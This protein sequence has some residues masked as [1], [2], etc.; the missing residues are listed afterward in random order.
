LEYHR[1]VLPWETQY[2][3]KFASL[4]LGIDAYEKELLRT[5][6]GQIL[7]VAYDDVVMEPEGRYELVRKPLL[8]RRFRT[9]SE[10]TA[11]LEETLRHALADAA[12]EGRTATYRPLATCSS[13]YDS[14]CVATLAKRLGC[15]EAVTVTGR[16]SGR[17]VGE[18]LGLMVQEFALHE[19]VKE[20]FADLAQFLATGMGGGDYSPFQALAPVL[21]KRVLLTGFHG[22]KIWDMHMEP[23]AVLIR[24]DTSGSS[25]QEFRLRH[26][27]IHIPVPMIGARRHADVW[28]ISHAAEMEPYQLHNDY[29]RP[30]PRRVLEESGVPRRM[31]GQSKKYTV[32]P[33]FA[34]A[35]L[36]RGEAREEYEALA[37]NQRAPRVRYWVRDLAWRARATL[38]SD[39]VENFM[40][41]AD[42]MKRTLVGDDRL[43]I[44]SRPG[45][46]LQFCVAVGVMRETYRAALQKLRGS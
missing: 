36:V 37:A 31:F 42:W 40:P 23:N 20:H 9:Y 13:G 10:Y 33:V 45:G 43:F 44:Q 28:T 39:M 29:D 4:V 14:A 19:C 12:R 16:D 1:V 26:D 21:G 6:K 32:L 38:L 7:R 3:R 35:N 2:G 27:F 11:Y 24:G 46:A 30:I 5:A 18:K 8:A 22:D 15:Q 25:V 41:W 34:I 17:A